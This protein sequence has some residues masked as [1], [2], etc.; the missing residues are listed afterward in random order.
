M[1]RNL[2][3]RD[4]FK[5]AGGAAVGLA[6]TPAPWKLLDDLS[7]WTQNGPWIPKPLR[8]DITT[9][10]SVCAICPAGC[11]LRAQ[12]VGGQPFSLFGMAEHPLSHG[13]LCPLGFTGHHLAYHPLRAVKPL[14]LEHNDAA[15]NAVPISRDAAIAEIAQAI[16]S[17]AADETIAV[18]DGRPGRTISLLYRQFLA[19][20]PN[21][22]Y[23]REPSGAGATLDTLQA[24]FEKPVG[25]LGL[26]LENTR[27]LL[28][29]GAPI[30]DGWGT[31]GRIMNLERNQSQLDAGQ[32]LR[33]IQIETRQSRTALFANHWLPIKPGTESALALGLANV[34]VREKLFDEPALQ[35]NAIDF[36]QGDNR[37]YLDLIGQ[38]QPERVAETTGINQETIVATAREAAQRG[39]AIAL[40][41]GDP[42]GGP[43]GEAEEIAIAGLNLLLGNLG[44]PG[45]IVG[46]SEVP[47]PAEM[48]AAAAISPSELAAIPDHSIRVLIMDAAESG[49]ALPWTLIEKKLVPER[50]VVVS[51]SPYLAGNAKHAHYLIPAPA[52]LESLQEI[53]TLDGAECSSFS[54]SAPLL[55]PPDG[56]TE[57]MDFVRSLATAANISLPGG[58]AADLLKSRVAAIY[59]NGQGEIFALADK[60]LTEIKEAGSAE[61]LWDMLK[62]GGCW[63]DSKGEMAALPRFSMLGKSSQG[64]EKLSLTVKGRLQPPLPGEYPLVLMPFGWRGAVG[65]GQVSPLMSKLYQESGLRDIGNQAFINP[66]TGGAMGLA[67]GEQA[68]IK[69]QLGSMTVKMRFDL[70]V[71]PGV[72]HVAVGPAP[73][74]TESA[75]E[76]AENIL[77]IC[78]IE[79]DSTWRVT[80]AQ[81]RKV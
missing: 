7:I 1:V 11:A 40:G 16:Q 35:R 81:A 9:R 60:K 12:C 73:N 27:T 67:D 20:L 58:S 30:L 79:S 22:V 50:A 55:T 41:G 36:K 46:R 80:P 43:L 47:T 78:Q 52:H 65:N 13:T 8:G 34:I 64:F 74:G 68:V 48:R 14:R 75:K 6:F 61:K 56:A 5:L 54:L 15:V 10:F 49:N 25:P 3:R 2:E 17:K 66:D 57:P 59:Q 26:D 31:P 63:I 77:K 71:M 37:S 19:G 32:R 28:S 51:L 42:G 23:L 45:G 18:I 72:L 24:L 39:P 29:F 69:T 53:P 38:F 76:I 70:A 33:I 44:K 4:L 62:G 21:G